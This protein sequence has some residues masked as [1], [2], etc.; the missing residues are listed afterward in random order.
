MEY[1]NSIETDRELAK[2]LSQF[3]TSESIENLARTT[4]FIERSTSRLTGQMFL[5]M[6]VFNVSRGEER[7]LND[8]CDYLEDTYGIEL[9]K[10]S[11]DERYNTYSVSFMKQ[12]YEKLLAEVLQPYVEPLNATDSENGSFFNSIE[13]IDATTF[14]LSSALAVF[15]KGGGNVSSSVKLHHRY[16][17]LRGET[18]GI[19]IVSGHENDACYLEDLNNH[20]TEKCLYIKD[21]GYVNLSHFE[22]IDKE[23]GY[24]L[25]R[26]RSSINCYIKDEAGNY[27]EVQMHDLVPAYGESKDIAYIYIG[28]K[29]IKVRMVIQ[30]IPEE[31]VERRKKKVIRNNKTHG[32]KTF[33]ENTLLL[34]YYNVYITNA[35]VSILPTDKIRLLYALRWQIELIFKIWKSIFDIDKVKQMNIF[36]FE[37][38]LYGRLMAILL[39]EKIQNLYRDY[40]WE[41]EEVEISEYKCAK[42]LK[43]T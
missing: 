13:L 25:S 18:L 15:Y 26:F 28:Q 5:Q 19:K 34:C 8:Q 4:K 1:P 35:D 11:L 24:F 32:S 12:C 16:E 37:C 6:N 30:S 20:L 21:L 33:H 42:I 39:S 23:K 29:K 38:Y 40:L 36:R 3:F 14:D 10:Q 41:E 22:R 43:K 9:K 17:L 2:R 31:F 27:E 7:S